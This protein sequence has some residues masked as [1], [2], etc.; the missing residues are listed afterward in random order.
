MK[1]MKPLTL[2]TLVASSLLASG[3]ASAELTGNVGLTSNYIWR[4]VTQSD[5]GPAAQGGVDYSHASGFY[6]GTWL[7]NVDFGDGTDANEYEHDL[8]LG[9]AGE[10]GAFGYDVG[11]FHYMYPLADDADFTELGLSGSYENFSAGVAYTFNSDIQEGSGSMFAEGDLYYF[12]SAGFD[13]PNDFGLG[14]TLGSYAFDEDSAGNELD[15]TH[16]QVA[17]SKADLTFA[18]D[19][20]DLDGS[21]SGKALD[22]PRFSVSWGM[23]F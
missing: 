6:A 22:D 10:A 2:G 18:L 19:Q 4:G 9:Y 13:L 21:M 8:Y 16:Y 5:D 12:V 20:N 17:L 7:S 15:Y 11:V 1:T 14:L 3:I 23:E